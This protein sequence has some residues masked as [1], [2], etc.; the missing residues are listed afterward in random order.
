MPQA[1]GGIFLPFP[2]VAHVAKEAP[3]GRKHQ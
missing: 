1:A 3:Y 2:S